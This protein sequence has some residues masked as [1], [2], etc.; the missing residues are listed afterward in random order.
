[1]D[2][3]IAETEA[4]ADPNKTKPKLKLPKFFNSIVAKMSPSKLA[5]D[6][7]PVK[8]NAMQLP[9]PSLSAAKNEH[10]ENRVISIDTWQNVST[11]DFERPSSAAG[12]LI[13]NNNQ[14]MVA[15]SLL[16]SPNPNHLASYTLRN[17]TNS[18]AV[19]NIG[20]Q[21]NFN[22]SNMNGLHIGNTNVY[23]VPTASNGISNGG[24]YGAE[25]GN[26]ASASAKKIDKTK[27][28]KGKQR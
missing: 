2:S 7:V 14:L 24:K 26:E 5:V 3:V 23:R 25:Q 10:E 18:L 21:N 4:K 17:S 1:M 27:S 11:E 8:K 28:I 15:P 13:A 19:A 6:A 12:E 20:V 9:S 22:L 16:V